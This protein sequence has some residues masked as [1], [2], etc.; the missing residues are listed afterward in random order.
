M[1]G[2]QFPLKTL[3]SNRGADFFNGFNCLFPLFHKKTFDQLFERQYS[4]NPPT[5]SGWYAVFNIVLAIASRLRMSHTPCEDDGMTPEMHME[6]AWDYFQNGASVM[7]ELLMKNSNL[8]SIQAIVGM[9][10]ELHTVFKL[11]LTDR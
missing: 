1:V 11:L 5:D 10:C 6:A 3:S 7:L 2:P 9:V 4:D 8:L